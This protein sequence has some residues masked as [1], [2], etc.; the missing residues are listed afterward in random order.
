MT[1]AGAIASIVAALAAWGYLF[2]ESGW[3]ANKDYLFLGMLPAATIVGIAAVMLVLVSLVTRP[4][5]REVVERFF[6]EEKPVIEPST[7][8]PFSAMR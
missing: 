7:A 4:P 8:T 2:H 1:T 6:T 5:A 3:G